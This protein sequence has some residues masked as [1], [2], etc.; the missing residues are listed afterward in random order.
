MTLFGVVAR[1]VDKLLVRRGVVLYSRTAVVMEA[2]LRGHMVRAVAL[3]AAIL[4]LV[5]PSLS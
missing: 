1:I 5:A 3:S 2:V 4:S